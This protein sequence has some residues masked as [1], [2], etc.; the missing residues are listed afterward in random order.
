MIELTRLNN[1][2]VVVNSDLIQCIEE[3]PDTVI[4]L[5]NGYKYV[6][7]EKPKE[8]VEKVMVFRR[9]ISCSISENKDTP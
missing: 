4:T 8:I 1:I 3:T 9:K 6:V 7:K 5:T 2:S